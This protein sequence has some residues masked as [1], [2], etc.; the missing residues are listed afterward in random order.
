M[1]RLLDDVLV[2]QQE[3]VGAIDAVCAQASRIIGRL[4][5]GTISADAALLRAAVPAQADGKVARRAP[6]RKGRKGF[7]T[8]GQD[9]PN[10]PPKPY[11]APQ[12]ERRRKRGRKV[13]TAQAPAKR[14]SSRTAE[15]AVSGAATTGETTLRIPFGN[16]EAALALSARYRAGGWYAPPG[17]SLTGFR[18]RGWL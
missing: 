3:M 4:T 8:S 6:P 11:E 14:R 5:D 12:R 17:V 16:K 1:E 9:A 2:G 15:V 13:H 18:E 7:R 10:V